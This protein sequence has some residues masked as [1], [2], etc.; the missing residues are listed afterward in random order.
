MTTNETPNSDF[1]TSTEGQRADEFTEPS[2]GPT[3]TRSEQEA[4]D[5]SADD[6]DLD[7][8]ETNYRDMTEKGR[9]AK[10]EGAL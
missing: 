5:R 3:P 10:G 8:V 1:D 6:V 2:A 4:A 7:Q 9:D